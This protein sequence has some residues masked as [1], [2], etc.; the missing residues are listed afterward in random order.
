MSFWVSR[1]EKGG[2]RSLY[3]LG[4]PIELLLIIVGII[5]T[6]WSEPVR[7]GRFA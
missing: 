4:I 7:L 6:F 2:R 3:L 5:F 1:K